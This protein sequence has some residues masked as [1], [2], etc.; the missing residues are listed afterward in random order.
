MKLKALILSTQGSAGWLITMSIVIVIA[1][2]AA[3][4]LI[5]GT[6]IDLQPNV[7]LIIGITV[8]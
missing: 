7:K 5:A 1:E 3:I 2:I 4:V 8:M 6:I